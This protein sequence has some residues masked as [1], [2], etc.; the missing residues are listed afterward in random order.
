MNANLCPREEWDFINRLRVFISKIMLHNNQFKQRP[1]MAEKN[2]DCI[3]EGRDGRVEG[4][5]ESVM[6]F[7]RVYKEREEEQDLISA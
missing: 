3:I 4:R 5:E 1:S 2:G 6:Y 7:C